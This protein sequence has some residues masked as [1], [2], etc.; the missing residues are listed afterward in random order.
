MYQ[1]LALLTGVTLAV[2]VSVNGNLTAAYSVFVAAAIVHL[3]GSLFALVLCAA[4]REKRPLW[5]HRPR[6]IYLGGAIGVFTT[7]FNNLAYGKISMTSIVALGLLGQTAAALAIDHFGLLGMEKR[8]FQKSSLI[9]LAFSLAGIRMMLDRTV[10]AAAVAV[11]VSLGAGVSVVLSRTVNARLAEQT[12]PLRG[13]LIN[14]LV[15]LPITV[16]LAL[17]SICL[18]GGAHIGSGAGRPWIY[19]GGVLG[20]AV[21]LLSNLTVPRVPA[22]R[23]TLLLF[24][25]QIFTGV[26]LDLLLGNSFSDATFRGGL[27]IA[28]G[29][30]VNLVVERWVGRKGEKGED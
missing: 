22:F 7:V 6:W 18:A 21:V 24:I 23:L 12:G 20:V 3:V 10:A 11:A 29:V 4:Q 27:V 28:A 19:L 16:A 25:G 17:G 14:H 2:M 13:S 1:L 15:G 30:I 5:G 26:L 9:G 8:P